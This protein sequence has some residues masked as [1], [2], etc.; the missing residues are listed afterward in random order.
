MADNFISVEKMAM[1][2][3]IKVKNVERLLHVDSRDP[4]TIEGVSMTIN[5]LPKD[6]L[7]KIV[8]N[9]KNL[10]PS[11]YVLREWVNAEYLDWQM[12]SENPY[13]IDLLNKRIEFE[14]NLSEE[15]YNKLDDNYK[16]NWLKLSK[17]PAAIDIL[18]KYPKDIVWCSLCDNTNPS[19]VDMILKRVEYEKQ[20]PPYPEHNGNDEYGFYRIWWD[21]LSC[22][23]HPQIIEMLKERIE[24]EKNEEHYITLNANDKIDWVQLSANKNPDAIRLLEDNLEKIDWSVLSSNPAAIELLKANYAKIIWRYLSINPNA[25]ELIKD[26]VDYEESLQ[27]EEYYKLGIYNRLSWKYLSGNSCAIELLKANPNRIDWR[28]LTVNPNAIE[29]LKTKPIGICDFDFYVGLCINPNAIEILKENKDLIIWKYLS[30]NP[31][32][33]ELLKERA[34]YENTLT[35][36]KY[37]NLGS[38]YRLDWKELSKHKTIFKIV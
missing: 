24:L 38:N 20:L 14:K 23:E 31:N 7:D 37:M 11:K 21:R 10:F 22:N 36:E 32:A 17:N 30:C 13:A 35:H 25:F 1:I 2:T 9:Y 3:N 18:K 34:E 8:Y 28:E 26:R 19:A 16:I 12:L 27:T 4:H 15:E 33:L 29:M 6:I 5:S